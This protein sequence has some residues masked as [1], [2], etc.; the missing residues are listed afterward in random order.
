MPPQSKIVTAAAL[1]SLHPANVLVFGCP[2][3]HC[4]FW[5]SQGARLQLAGRKN[6]A[7]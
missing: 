1:P 4:A 6:T 2:S 7:W 5:W 3:I